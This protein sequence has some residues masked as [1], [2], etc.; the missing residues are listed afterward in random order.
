MSLDMGL[1]FSPDANYIDFVR[2]RSPTL[3]TF[4]Y[5]IPRS[6]EHRTSRCRGIDFGSVTPDGTEFAFA[7]K[8]APWKS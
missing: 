3:D 8:L 2:S 6:A 4:L 7:G 5:R 1:T